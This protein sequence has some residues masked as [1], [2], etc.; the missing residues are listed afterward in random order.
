MMGAPKD[1]PGIPG[2]LV[3]RDSTI[4]LCNGSSRGCPG[5][6]GILS[7]EGSTTYNIALC[8]GSSQG[9]PGNPGILSIEGFYY[10][11]MHWE[12][13]GMSRESRDP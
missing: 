10:S 9:C 13:P 1:V 3:L 5:N 11:P 2:Y 8:D 6:P 4:A 12:F 7:I